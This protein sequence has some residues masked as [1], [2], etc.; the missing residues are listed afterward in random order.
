MELTQHQV[1]WVEFDPTKGAEIRKT[2]PC[3]ILSPAEMNRHLATVV[4]APMTTTNR[5]LPTRVATK[6]NGK[7][8]Y[9]ALEQMQTIAQARIVS[10]GD[11]LSRAVRQHVQSVIKAAFVD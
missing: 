9:I 6:V 5:P 2:R 10:R 11:V 7:K 4:V 1:V 8:G 3:V